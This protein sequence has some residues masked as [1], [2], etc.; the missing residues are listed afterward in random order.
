M[1][2]MNKR[3]MRLK[4]WEHSTESWSASVGPLSL[5]VNVVPG[6][7]VD[8]T[9]ARMSSHLAF[10]HAACRFD[11]TDEAEEA[12]ERIIRGWLAEVEQK[13]E[14]DAI[15]KPSCFYCTEGITHAYCSPKPSEPMGGDW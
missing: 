7:T 4:W 5:H 12:A 10:G 8:W 1:A 2:T 9:V 3:K 15:V 6:G 11:A 14:P 13:S